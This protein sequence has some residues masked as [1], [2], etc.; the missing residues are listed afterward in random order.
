MLEAVAVELERTPFAWTVPMELPAELPPPACTVPT[1]LPVL[2]PPE[3]RLVVWLAEA[4]VPVGRFP[5]PAFAETVV[6]LAWTVP[7]EWSAEFP[8]PACTVPTEFCAVLAALPTVADADAPAVV[9][10]T[11]ALALGAALVEPTWTVPIDP[12]V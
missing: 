10:A 2:F 7:A 6:S 5:T 1:D 9:P 4:L 12:P 11:V 3:P 8:P